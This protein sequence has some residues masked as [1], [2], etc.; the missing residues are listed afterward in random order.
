VNAG[1]ATGKALAAGNY[2][3]AAYEASNVVN[4]FGK[5]GGGSAGSG[6]VRMATKSG[7][8]RSSRLANRQT[9]VY[10]IDDTA[11]QDVY[12]WGISSG[13]LTKSGNLPRLYNQV[14]KLNDEAGYNRYKGTIVKR[15]QK[16]EDGINT[17]RFYASLYK[18]SMNRMPRGMR[19]PKSGFKR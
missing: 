17:E 8:V 5:V 12:K 11:T 13:Q 1:I 16:R 2:A 10:R 4:P 19:Y 15:Y 6:V 3:L 9:S 14:K 7:K 18:N